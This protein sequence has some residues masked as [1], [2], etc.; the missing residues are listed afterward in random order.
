MTS[1]FVYRGDTSSAHK[2]VTRHRRS[3]RWEAHLWSRTRGKQLYLGGFDTEAEA[4]R[5]FDVCSL[6]KWRDEGKGH[7]LGDGGVVAYQGLNFE[8]GDYSA[9]APVI[10]AMS[11]EDVVTA[12][13]QGKLREQYA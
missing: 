4:A 11:L 7:G 8:F 1:C 3:G 12:V 6:K 2:G 13:R 5:A 10:D 9:V